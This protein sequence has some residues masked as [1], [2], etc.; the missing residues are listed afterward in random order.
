[1]NMNLMEAFMVLTT[2]TMKILVVVTSLGNT[3]K[4]LIPGVCYAMELSKEHNHKYYYVNFLDEE[5]E[6]LRG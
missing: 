6:C 4:S 5:I 3:E 1:M 2:M